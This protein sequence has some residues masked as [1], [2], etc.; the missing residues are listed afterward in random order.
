MGY[1]SKIKIDSKRPLKDGTAALFMQVIIDRKKT[2]IDLDIAWPPKSFSEVHLCRAR[3]RQDP[4]VEEYNII[5]GNA[6]TK[7]NSIHK[8]YLM[9]GIHLTL[10]SFIKEYRSNLNKNDFIQYFAQKSY[11][12]WN[13]QKISDDTYEKEKGTITKL[14]TF[15]PILPFHEFQSDWAQEFDNHLKRKFNNDHNTRWMRHKHL[16]TYLHIARD[17]DKINFNNPYQRFKNKLVEGSWK[18]LELAQMKMLIEK[19]LEWKDKPLPLLARK[20]GV[21]QTDTREGLTR[22]EIIVLRRFLFSCNCA[23]RISDLQ[24]L[25]KSMFSNGAMT[26]TPNKTEKYGTKI[27]SVPLNDVAR[28]M[29]DDEIIDNPGFKV[30]DRYSD[31]SSNR[32]LKRV[33][34]KSKLEINLHHHVARYTFASLMDQAGA[35]HTGLMAYMGLKKRQTLEKYVKPNSKVIAGDIGKMNEM[36]KA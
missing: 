4:D 10:E 6:R 31:Q 24:E 5:I 32:L 3:T 7:A 23:L 21:K 12:R 17:V 22:A 9:R 29:L 20:N 33:A 11:E 26:I 25:D 18:P 19:Y 2:R 15:A 8:D 1:S 14:K 27:T 16:I 13:K 28:L 34:E 30:F 35:N 36:I